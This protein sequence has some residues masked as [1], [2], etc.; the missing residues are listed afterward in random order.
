[1]SACVGGDCGAYDC[2]LL[3]GARESDDDEDE[4]CEVG[5]YCAEVA[6]GVA[7]EMGALNDVM[8]MVVA[9]LVAAV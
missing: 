5:C 9:V 7:A 2:V 8:A 6:V 3:G 4:Y 1:M